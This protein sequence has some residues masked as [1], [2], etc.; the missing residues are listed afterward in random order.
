MLRPESL[1]FNNKNL[2]WL[3]VTSKLNLF[4]KYFLV[5]VIAKSS[6]KY[7][8]IRHFN[9]TNQSNTSM[10]KYFLLMTSLDI[11]VINMLLIFTIHP[12]E[13]TPLGVTIKVLNITYYSCY[14]HATFNSRSITSLLSC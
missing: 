4:V 8:Y 3:K 14:F 13:K 6:A 12:I 5:R 10:C 9:L 11:F 7:K 1:S 2:D